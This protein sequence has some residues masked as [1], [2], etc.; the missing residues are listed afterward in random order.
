M[1][2]TPMLQPYSAA[3]LRYN[4]GLW[5][6]LTFFFFDS[7]CPV[8]GQGHRNVRNDYHYVFEAKNSRYYYRN[9]LFVSWHIRNICGKYT[10]LF[11]GSP[12]SVLDKFTEDGMKSLF[13]IRI[14]CMFEVLDRL[15]W[16]ETQGRPRV[17]ATGTSSKQSK[18]GDLT[19]R[20]P[21]RIRQIEKTYDLPSLNADQLIPLLGKE[22]DFQNRM[23]RKPNADG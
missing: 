14:P 13:L 20:L 1:I 21:R 23:A 8:D 7:V 2:I 17:G 15:Y 18:P 4:A 3:A 10:R 5:S 22:L 11:F 6:W 19:Y 9:H 16:D 12:V